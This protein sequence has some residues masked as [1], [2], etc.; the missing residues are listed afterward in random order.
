MN[1]SFYNRVQDTAPSTSMSLIDFLL[2]VKNGQ[3][4]DQ[5]NQVKQL[6]DQQ[7]TV[8]A[9]INEPQKIEAQKT[10]NQQ[11][12]QELKKQIL[13]CSYIEWII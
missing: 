7:Q 13:P 2:N 5:F 10:K 8:L 3:W 11:A 1:I 9:S 6:Q 4:Q 12:K